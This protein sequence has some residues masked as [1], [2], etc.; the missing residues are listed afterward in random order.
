MQSIATMKKPGILFRLLIIVSLLSGINATSWS[1]TYLETYGQNRMQHRSFNWK[2]FETEHF[3]IY[4]YD[5]TGKNL[6]RY[7]A[8]QAENDIYAVERKAGG[9]FPGKF[10]II[11][12]NSYDEYRQTNIGRKADGQQLQSFSAGQI[13]IVDDKL[14]VYFTGIHT[15]LRRQIRTGMTRIVMEKSIYGE[16]VKQLVKNSGLNDLPDWVTEGYIAYLVDGWNTET[17]N[18]WKAMV[19]ADTNKGFHSLSEKNPELVGKAFWKYI[20]ERYGKAEVKVLLSVIQDKVNLN[21]AL[22]SKYK[23][24]VVKVYDSCMA[25][26][27]T[28]YKQD[29]EGR[30]VPEMDKAMLKIKVPQDGALIRNIRVSPKGDD[31]A[32]VKWKDGEFQVCLQRTR[33]SKELSVIMEGGVKNYNESADP[34]YPLLAWSNTG[35]KLAILYKRKNTT[36][37]RI[38]DAIKGRIFNYVVPPRRF[39]RALGMAFDEDNDGIIM[40]A[41]RKS[42]TDLYLFTI[43]GSKLLNI[44]NDVWDDVQPSFVTGGSKRGIIFL[45]NRP[46][47]NMDVP[48]AVN[49]LPTGLMNVFFYDTKTQRRELLQC[50][51]ATGE[52][53]ISQPIQYGSDNFAYLSDV[54]GIRNKFVVVRGR[55]RYN[56]DSAYSVPS[57]NYAHGIISHQYNPAGNLVADVIQQ[58]DYYYV[59]FKPLQIPGKDMAAKVL[60]PSYLKEQETD[61]IGI[62]Q[63]P[64]PAPESNIQ[65]APK[66]NQ[67][68]RMWGNLFGSRRNTFQSEFSV[69]AARDSVDRETDTT[70]VTEPITY[71]DSVVVNKVETLVVKDAGT[72]DSTYIKMKA[73]PYRLRFKANKL[74]V[75]LDN[76][77]LF[78]KYQP[79]GLNGSTYTNPPLGGMVTASIDDVLENYRFTGGFRLPLEKTGSAYFLQY[80]NVKRRLDWNITYLHTSSVNRYQVIFTDITGT[81]IFSTTEIGKTTTDLVQGSFSYPFDRLRSLRVQLGFRQ[82]ALH[83]KA[84]DTFSLL[85]ET[86][87]NYWVTS[88]IEYV[89]DNTRFI[90]TNIRNGIRYKFFFEYMSQMNGNG[91]GLYNIGYDFRNYAKIWKNLIWALRV[92]GANSDGKQ[93]ILYFL[94]GVDNWLNSQYSDFM[95]VSQNQTY[96]FQALATNLRG[97][98]QNARNGNS[99]AVVNSEF[100]FPLLTS[101]VK[102]PIK[103]KLLRNLQVVAFA[104][105]GA[106]WN[107]LL[108]NA[109]NITKSYVINQHPVNVSV[110][111][112]GSSGLAI[113]YGAGLRTVFWGY[114]L[115]LDAAWNV[116]GIK[117]P[118]MYLSFGTDF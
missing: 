70:T 23:M 82:D 83:F 25:Y 66:K 31:V 64:L 54:N 97:Y 65:V 50:S 57:T 85:M 59:Y 72:G 104:D 91:G 69:Q 75:G 118:I 110:D 49:E 77:V 22:K 38:Y 33:G 99:Y 43:K 21:K 103:S 1:Q 78:N 61:R 84:L 3:R 76:N 113:G 36:Y 32:Y 40:S 60:Q 8:E 108:P 6:A 74:S 94:G 24:N 107:G 55:N 105:A 13:S 12:Y 30:E 87:K 17:D 4:H 53:R 7:V 58:G 5:A 52:S 44:T 29:E 101:F 9:T 34:D 102:R 26:Y 18:A 88:R 71:N 42:Q 47:P 86:Q 89:F 93:K 90:T 45:S 73:V 62:L 10:N 115:R 16:N 112:P 100:R 95:P 51:N 96:G 106:A 63:E 19:Q 28:V 111:I 15:D 98:K 116:E 41:I 11:I 67:R 14:V 46:K 2:L 39:D 27:R 20:A 68:N 81:P 48:S 56:Y 79:S 117:T 35:F 37:L 109:D 114:D 92:A 80:E